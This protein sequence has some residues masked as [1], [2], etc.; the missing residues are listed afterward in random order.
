MADKPTVEQKEKEQNSKKIKSTDGKYDLQ[1]TSGFEKWSQGVAAGFEVAQDVLTIA[2]ELDSALTS[3]ANLNL[4]GSCKQVAQLNEDAPIGSP[5]D[6]A[7]DLGSNYKNSI[8]NCNPYKDLDFS[9]PTQ[10]LS[11]VLTIAETL[12]GPPRFP[13]CM[14]DTYRQILSA[15]PVEYLL[16]NLIKNLAAGTK[17]PIEKIVSTQQNTPCGVINLEERLLVYETAMP[18]FNIPLIPELPY[19]SIPDL[20]DIIENIIYETICFTLCA[21]VT[22]LINTISKALY[23]SLDTYSEEIFE[24]SINESEALYKQSSKL[25]SLNKIPIRPFLEQADLTEAKNYLI[26]RGV[27]PSISDEKIIDYIEKVQGTK[28]TTEEVVEISQEEFV[29]LLL[30]KMPCDLYAKINK[31][32]ETVQVFKLENETEVINFF[33]IVGSL[34]NMIALAQSSKAKVCPPDPC[35]LKPDDAIGDAIRDLCRLLSPQ[36]GIDLSA[37]SL[38][39]ATKTDEQLAESIESICDTFASNNQSYNPV[40]N[41][42]KEETLNTSYFRKYFSAMGVSCQQYAS[43]KS[44]ENKQ[45]DKNISNQIKYGVERYLNYSFPF[46]EST[47]RGKIEETGQKVASWEDFKKRGA[48]IPGLSPNTDSGGEFEVYLLQTKEVVLN[49]IK[50]IGEFST[51]KSLKV[52]DNEKV[53]KEFKDLKKEYG[54]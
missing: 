23:S 35:E 53:M 5:G 16:L 15:V 14:Y 32:D 9:N 40:Y 30:G 2:N 44:E 19:I 39:S 27:S 46:V 7:S 24:I 10:S 28:P 6:F 41:T 34:I 22:P 33:A 13:S 8:T 52:S 36:Q 45:S 38:L 12:T 18:E 48:T 4:N 20:T 29:F 47:I 25:V 49:R 31:I 37:N 21:A 17:T 42:N 1:V 11:S 54:L 3:L 26:S 50:Q 43:P 51:V